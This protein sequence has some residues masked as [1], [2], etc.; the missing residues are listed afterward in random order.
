M[1]LPTALLRCLCCLDCYPD[2][3]NET[4]RDKIYTDF[5]EAYARNEDTI[6]RLWDS[7]LNEQIRLRVSLTRLYALSLTSVIHVDACGTKEGGYSR[8]GRA[9]RARAH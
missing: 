4:L 7:I 5:Q 6:R 9:P 8:T 2:N 1:T 3:V